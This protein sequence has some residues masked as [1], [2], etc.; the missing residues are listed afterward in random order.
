MGINV[1]SRRLACMLVIMFCASSC[2]MPFVR[3]NEKEETITFK[4]YSTDGAEDP[5]SDP[6]AKEITKATGVTLKSDYPVDGNDKRIDLM[7]A[8]GEYPDFI[9]AK[10][11][12]EKLIE[13]NSLLDLSKLIDEY[14]PN[15]KKL[16]GDQYERLR[17]SEEDP[18]IYQLCVSPVEDEILDT[19]GNAQLQWAVIMANNYKIPSTLEEYETMIKD[20][21][22]EHNQI[23]GKDTIGLTISCSDWHWYTT[24]SNPSGYIANGS[25]DNGQ[26]IID[27]DYTAHYKHAAK[28]QKEFYQWMNKMYHEGIL[29][30]EFATQT[31]EDY[32]E[33]IASGRVLGLFD[34][35]W[36]YKSAQ[37]ALEMDGFYERTYAK[38]PITID[39]SV[40]CASLQNQGLAFGWGVGITKSCKDPV[41]AVKFLDWF[42]T[43]E[44]QTLISW[45]IEGVNYEY[46]ASGKR[47]QLDKDKELEE[48]NP[49]YSEIT[50][51]GYHNYPFPTYGSKVKDHT[52]N[53]INRTNKDTIVNSYN[54]VEKMA[55][56]K[57]NLKTLTEMFP[58]EDMFREPS[59]APIW[60]Q[61]FHSGIQEKVNNLDNISW[62]MLIKCIMC[63]PE[64]FDSTWDKFQK[65]LEDAGL[66]QVESEVT[67]QVKKQVEFWAKE[68]R[69]K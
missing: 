9:F 32:L 31:H 65:M 58:S 30:P 25:P 42:C 54:A 43:E 7:I 38:L 5:W 63:N 28:R 16:Y 56:E 19:S 62:K 11:D 55:L 48:N 68:K 47:K 10:G 66:K 57:L 12:A 20:Y 64:D 40:K 69:E 49:N 44:A 18:S 15:I 61:T 22:K 23:G 8:T 53:Y 36:D 29:D 24:L 67:R 59:F 27:E 6:V 3:K 17:Y 1:W 21:I 60:S 4:F 41:R 37:H 51:I 14:G 26:W 13:Q 35:E 52:G 39:K 34:Q 46:D 45:G 33:K 50:G 2:N